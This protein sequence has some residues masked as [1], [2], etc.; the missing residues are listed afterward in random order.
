MAAGVILHNN[1]HRNP[2]HWGKLTQRASASIIEL[3]PCSGT[4]R[5][6]DIPPT[7]L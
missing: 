4:S 1:P 7:H 5:D 3:S 6:A 2:L